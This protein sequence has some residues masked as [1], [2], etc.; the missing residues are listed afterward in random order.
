MGKLNSLRDSC[1]WKLV[2][3]SGQVANKHCSWVAALLPLFGKEDGLG[4]G[5]LSPECFVSR[6]VLLRGASGWVAYKPVVPDD[7]TG[8]EVVAAQLPD[9]AA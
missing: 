8:V 2:W 6:K 9:Q 4:S 7:K 1:T 3:P 5:H